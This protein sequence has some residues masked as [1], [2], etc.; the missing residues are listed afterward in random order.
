MSPRYNVIWF[1]DEYNTLE[2]IREKA[3]MNGINLIGYTNAV[4]GIN[5][6][7]KN[8][9]NYD[10]AIV[11]GK[12]F[13]TRD[14]YTND[15]V[16]DKALFEVAMAIEKISDRK[17]IPWFILSG[18]ISFTRETNKYAD[19]F[20][21]NEVFDK[22]SSED[23]EKLWRIL[24]TEADKQLETQ[25]RH[26]HD[27]L[28]ALFNQGY[29]DGSVEHQVLRLLMQPKPE[30]KVELKG[31]LTNIRSIH[32]SVFNKLEVIGIIPDSQA[33][34]TQII[35]HLS[36]NKSRQ[37]DYEPTSRVYQNDSIENLQK[38]VHF[39]CSKYIH[40]LRDDNYN[41]YMISN[42]AVE[43]LKNGLLEILLWFKKTYEE[44]VAGPRSD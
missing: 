4:E 29:L 42:Y 21:N 5:E 39:T 15:E 22:T 28:F 43:S 10:A 17:K 24:K 36:G 30:N 26:D 13:A 19:V 31:V 41:D 35:Q 20:K 11:D 12:F 23:L 6:L 44:N 34:P 25:L 2:I 18:Q 1:D 38:W 32:E 9:E 40:N 33:K 3:L 37:S 7:E 14:R 27:S 8:V 16:D